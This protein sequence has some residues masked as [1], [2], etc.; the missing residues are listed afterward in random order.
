MIPLV[1]YSFLAWIILGTVQPSSGASVVISQESLHPEHKTAPLGWE[2]SSANWDAVALHLRNV[3]KTPKRNLRHVDFSIRAGSPIDRASSSKSKLSSD[4]KLSNNLRM[5]PEHVSAAR[6]FFDILDTNDDQYLDLPEFL[7]AMDK[8]EP[9]PPAAPPKVLKESGEEIFENFEPE[10]YMNFQSFCRFLVTMSYDA[11]ADFKWHFEDLQALRND[12]LAELKNHTST[13][14]MK[15][16]IIFDKDSNGDVDEDEFEQVYMSNLY[17]ALRYK[18]KLP[19]GILD[20]DPEYQFAKKRF[21]RY[22]RG[23]G[24]LGFPD[25]VRLVENAAEHRPKKPVGGG[26]GCIS[27]RLMPK[28][29]KSS[30]TQ[31]NHL[32]ALNVFLISIAIVA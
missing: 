24:T 7:N 2:L 10:G 6:K 27:C 14:L 21:Q 20:T 29:A 26:K 32:W 9:A 5:F 17:W 4:D 25:F 28:W 31:V 3:L 11:P 15:T 8:T 19:S 12:Q 13:Q 1:T 30:V 18:E 23:T 16:F 22:T